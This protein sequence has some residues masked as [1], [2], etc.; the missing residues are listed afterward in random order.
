VLAGLAFRKRFK[1]ASFLF[2]TAIASLIVPSIVTSLGIALEFRILDDLAQACRRLQPAD[3]PAGHGP[4]LGERLGE[5]HTI[6][7]RDQML[8]A[9]RHAARE[10]ET[11]VDLVGDDPQATLARKV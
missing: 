3:P 11:A 6:V 4:V 10:V 8:K 2:Y 7:R 9:R 1:G 5:Q